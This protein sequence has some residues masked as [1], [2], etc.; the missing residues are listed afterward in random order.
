MLEIL[1]L[2]SPASNDCYHGCGG[3]AGDGGGLQ[4]GQARRD[5]RHL[6]QR[7]ERQLG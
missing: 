4:A 3:G 1:D 7:R 6:C 5:H 2:F